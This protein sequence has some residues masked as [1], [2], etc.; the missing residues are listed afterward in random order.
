M[1]CV[2]RTHINHAQDSAT[3]LGDCTESPHPACMPGVVLH[4]LRGAQRVLDPSALDA[5]LG[6]DIQSVSAEAHQ[7]FGVTHLR[8]P[9]AQSRKSSL[10]LVFDRVCASTRFTIT[11]QDSDGPGEPSGSGLPGS[12]PGT[13][14]E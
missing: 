8:P 11:A 9:S 7:P 14:T 6:Q 10:M 12:E 13:T 1:Q 5:T 3:P 4:G 2:T